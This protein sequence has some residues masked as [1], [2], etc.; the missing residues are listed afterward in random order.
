MSS[1]VYVPGGEGKSIIQSCDTHMFPWQQVPLSLVTS[2][3]LQVRTL[4]VS[5]LPMDVRLRELYLLFRCYEV[6]TQT[7]YKHT[8]VQTYYKITCICLSVCLWAD[9]LSRCVYIAPTVGHVCRVSIFNPCPTH[10]RI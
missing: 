3:V 7:L 1:H 5:G 8:Y 9:L 2:L 6:Y 10:G 4:F